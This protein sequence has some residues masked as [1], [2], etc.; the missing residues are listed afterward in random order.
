MWYLTYVLLVNYRVEWKLR[1]VAWRRW[2]I[3]EWALQMFDPMIDIK[4]QLRLIY[5]QCFIWLIS[6]LLWCS[7]KHENNNYA[8]GERD[9]ISSNYS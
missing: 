5:G 6:L 9:L 4:Y 8:N 1:L 2:R 3:H 7:L